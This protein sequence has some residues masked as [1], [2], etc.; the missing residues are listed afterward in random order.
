MAC[1]WTGGVGIAPIPLP[2]KFGIQSEGIS[3][4]LAGRASYNLN[5]YYFAPREPYC[6]NDK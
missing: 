2:G 3:Y 6:A 4:T 5:G 1:D